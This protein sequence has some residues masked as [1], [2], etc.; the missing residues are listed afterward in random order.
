MKKKISNN[1]GFTLVEVLAALV[2]L[3]I[4][5]LLIM[6]LLK[7]STDTYSQEVTANEQLVD[8]S[9]ILKLVTKDARRSSNFTI[10]ISNNL[11]IFDNNGL[12]T[13]QYEFDASNKILYRIDSNK[14][15]IANNVE[16][17][18]II[19]DPLDDTKL[20]IEIKL[21]DTENQTKSGSTE[22]FF[23]K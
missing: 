22:I 6:Q 13:A 1:L 7:S 23:R 19:Q 15:T 2:I 14:Q 8:V 4:V 3:S 9:Y 11:L 10:S 20:S 5:G 17:F 21:T 12:N 16:T 18:N